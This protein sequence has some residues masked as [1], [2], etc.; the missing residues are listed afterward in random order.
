MCNTTYK[1]SFDLYENFNVMKGATHMGQKVAYILCVCCLLS[2]CSRLDLRASSH[3]E[4]Q[5]PIV[6]L[7]LA[8]NQKI[9]IELYPEAAPN[10]V[11]NFISLI[12]DGYYDGLIF[13]RIIQDYIIQSGDPLGNN[14]GTPG[15]TIKGE[16]KS[17]GFKNSLRHTK[18]VVSMARGSKYDSAGSQF[19]I[20]VQDAEM[21]NGSYAAFGKVIEGIDIVEAIGKKEQES[22][23]AERAPLVIEKVTVDT[24]A[25]EYPEPIVTPIS[26][27]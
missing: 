21:L 2:G 9:I 12:E 23:Q 17:N 20:T 15:Y 19:F 13:H 1:V 18:G 7:V 3:Y 16:F 5:N 22:L 25:G 14:Y 10:T 8:D 4:M 11:N 27:R 26:S 6:T 24:K